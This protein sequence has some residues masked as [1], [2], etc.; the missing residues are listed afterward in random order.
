[1][2]LTVSLQKVRPGIS[3]KKTGFATQAE[4]KKLQKNLKTASM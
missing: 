3:A 1:M 2:K 4:V